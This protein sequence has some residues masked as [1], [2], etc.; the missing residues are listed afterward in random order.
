LVPVA[1]GE[2]DRHLGDRAYREAMRITGVS[3]D[4]EAATEDALRTAARG[5]LRG[6]DEITP[7]DLLPPFDDSAHFVSMAD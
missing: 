6:T 2:R 4:A 5:A 7:D 3:E 1:V